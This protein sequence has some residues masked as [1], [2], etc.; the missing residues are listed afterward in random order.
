MIHKIA[1]TILSFFFGIGTLLVGATVVIG[2]YASYPTPGGIVA[3]SIVG[4]IF[5]VIAFS[6]FNTLRKADARTFLAG[7]SASPDLDNLLPSDGSKVKHVTPEGL[8]KHFESGKMKLTSGW[9]EI[10]GV[11]DKWGEEKIREIGQI[12]YLKAKDELVIAFNDG[13]SVH[14]LEPETIFVGETYLKL[15]KAGKVAVRKGNHSVRLNVDAAFVEI[16]DS[17]KPGKLRL[18]ANFGS[19]AVW[20]WAER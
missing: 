18:K 5:C 16:E 10:Y 14:V 7:P 19:P 1:Q 8:V 4:A 12:Q 3:C 2:I 9:L 15:N 11:S 20:I 13:F 17:M 6:V